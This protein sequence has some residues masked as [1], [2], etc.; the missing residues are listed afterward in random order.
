MRSCWLVTLVAVMVLSLDLLAARSLVASD[1]LAEWRG[2]VE[3][4]QADPQLI[5]PVVQDA[6]LA[7][8]MNDDAAGLAIADT[9]QPLLLR[10]YGS[11]ETLP[12][13]VQLGLSQHTVASGETPGAILRQYGM[14]NQ[15]LQLLNPTYDDRR[16]GPGQRLK[17]MQLKDRML[18]LAVNKSVYRSL[19]V[20]SQPNQSSQPP[21][22]IWV[23]PCGLGVAGRDTPVGVTTISSK[24]LD[25]TWT[26]PDTKEVIPPHDPRNVLGGYWIALAAGADDRFRSIGLHGYTGAPSADWLE[27]PGSRGCVR[28]LQADIHALYAWLPLG[29]TVLITD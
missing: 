1:E 18:A 2:R 10:L 24:V 21:Q 9:V 26:H 7:I 28:L 11:G 13:M 17:V 6:G 15:L 16:L 8:M 19:L 4:A 3:R 23:A 29:A 22:L 25:P 20:A 27:Q 12:G 5:V 14:S